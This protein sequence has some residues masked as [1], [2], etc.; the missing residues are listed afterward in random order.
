MGTTGGRLLGMILKGYPRISESFISSEILLLESLGV[1]MEIYSLRRP[2]ESFVHPHVRGIKAGVTYIPE[3]VLPNLGAIIRSNSELA[4]EI[5]CRYAWCF[6]RAI[7]RAFSLRKTATIR[8]FLQAGHLARTKLS[9]PA[10]G[11]IHAHF[12]HTP[13]SVAFFASELTGLPFSFTAHAKDIYTSDAEQL[14]RKIGAAR[15]VVTCNRYNARFLSAAAENGGCSTPIHTIYHGIDTG[16]FTFA[17]PSTPAPPYRILSV[18]R[19]VAKKGYDDLLRALAILDRSGLGFCFTHIGTGDLSETIT[20]MAR[21]CGLDGKVRFMG[22]L[23]H[24][25]VISHYRDAHCFVLASKVAG[26][27]DRDGIPNVLVEAMACGVPVVSTHVSAIP[28]LVEDRSTGLLVPPGDPSAM[29][30][31]I[32][33]VL[34]GSPAARER[35]ARARAKVETEFDNRKCVL[36][37]HA[38]FQRVLNSDENRSLLSE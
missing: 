35:A 24:D 6:R 15:F 3:Y 8:H 5:G 20:R 25:S 32:R 12:C 31:A 4:R 10:V 30:G 1:P 29:A 9:N 21:E 7:A 13:A 19:L 18:G 16:Y 37:L 27:G 38:L 22:T 17:A 34:I 36:K 2:R 11:H 26:N 14:V 23:A 28:E 33:E